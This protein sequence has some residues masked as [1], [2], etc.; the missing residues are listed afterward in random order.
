[1]SK[2]IALTDEIKKEISPLIESKVQILSSGF[3]E[4]FFYEKP[5]KKNHLVYAGSLF[6]FGKS[7]GL[8]IL[9]KIYHN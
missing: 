8:E 2:V 5:E 9:L 6:R 1:M 7:R 3:D 4:D